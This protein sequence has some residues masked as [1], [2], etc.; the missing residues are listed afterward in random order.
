MELQPYFG[1][2]TLSAASIVVR[3]S[4]EDRNRA[5]ALVV[6]TTKIKEVVD[7]STFTAAKRA[8][9]QLKALIKEIDDARK[10]AKRPFAAVETA[11]EDLAHEVSSPVSSEMNR[12]L[13]LLNRYVA[14]LERERAEADRKA[15]EAL[16][17]ER[18]EADRKVREAQAAKEEAERKARAAQ[19]EAERLRA[20]QEAQARSLALEQAKLERE[21]DTEV[22]GPPEPRRGLVPGGRVD[23]PRTYK[24][25]DVWAIIKAKRLDLLR[26]ELNISACNDEV[27]RQLE[28]A[29]DAEPVIPGVEITTQISV[30]V[31]AQAGARLN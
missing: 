27:R 24:L 22:I 30:S 25:K 8:A 6:Q 21:L 1:E 16:E 26:I 10:A 15:K 17:R 3:V 7:E 9:G 29:P 23:H 12:I 4:K 14:K 11:I 19:D 5:E 28:H 31:K 20:Q 18:A 13:T 2:Q